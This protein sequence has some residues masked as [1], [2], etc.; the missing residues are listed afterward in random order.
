M[1]THLPTNN[2]E[3][4]W[5]QDSDR[6]HLRC[7][8]LLAILRIPPLRTVPDAHRVRRLQRV[9][10]VRAGKIQPIPD[11]QRDREHRRGQ[12]D[13]RGRE[14]QEAQQWILRGRG[15]LGLL[16]KNSDFQQ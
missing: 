11:F 16:K 14:I 4:F 10:G 3:Q 2:Q 5:G 9:R 8:F 7:P 15:L 6:I 1:K 12:G 13:R